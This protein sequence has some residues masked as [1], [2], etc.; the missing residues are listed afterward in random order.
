MRNLSI[1]G[2][3]LSFVVFINCQKKESK[4]EPETELT[5]VNYLKKGKEIAMNSQKALG[6]QLM[7]KLKEGGAINALEFCSENA[8]SI[9]DSLSKVQNVSIKRVSDK[10]RN[11]IN[12]ANEDEIKYINDTKELLAKGSDAKPTIKDFQ[13]KKVGYYPIVTNAMC[14]QC[15]GTPNEQISEETFA[16]INSIYPEDKAIAYGENELRGIWVIEMNEE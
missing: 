9:T 11:P 14:L 12:F 2:L 1:L 16:K 7:K 3:L 5:E 6:G 13:D 15:H 4:L 8:I 10:S